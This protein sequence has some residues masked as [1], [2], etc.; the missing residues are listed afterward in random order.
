MSQELGE[1]WKSYLRLMDVFTDVLTTK[2][3]LM[4]HMVRLVRRNGGPYMY[5]TFVD[6]HL[7]KLLKQCLRLCHQGNFEGMGFSKLDI[8]L[9]SALARHQFRT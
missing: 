3:H 8:A 1:I 4:G 9:Q 7:N 6:E 2:D 5:A